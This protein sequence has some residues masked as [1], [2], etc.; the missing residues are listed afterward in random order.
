MAFPLS[1]MRRRLDVDPVLTPEGNPVTPLD[2]RMPAG[3]SSKQIDEMFNR[4]TAVALQR[5]DLIR[6]EDQR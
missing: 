6:G 4:G 5:S 2:K 3:P 1:L